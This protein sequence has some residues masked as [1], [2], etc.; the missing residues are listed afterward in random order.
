MKSNLLTVCLGCIGFATCAADAFAETAYPLYVIETESGTL[1]APVS[2]ESLS[3]KKYAT[4]ES[5]EEET[6]FATISASS[7]GAGTFVKRGSGY[8]MGSVAFTNFTGEVRVEKGAWVVDRPGMCGSNLSSASA[9]TFAV[10]NGAAFVCAATSASFPS[11]GTWG[12]CLIRYTKFFFEGTGPDGLGAL[13]NKS[14]VSMN[15]AC[16]N[17]TMTLTGDATFGEIA[18]VNT[19]FDLGSYAVI[20]LQG[21]ELVI[22]NHKSTTAC[23][24]VF[25]P[26]CTMK[27]P[28]S[29]R[30][31]GTGILFQSAP[32]F[33]GDSS[34]RFTF[35]K[36]AALQTWNAAMTSARIPWTLC[37]T[38]NSSLSVSR[39]ASEKEFDEASNYFDAPVVIDQNRLYGY[40]STM[41][42]GLAFNGFVSG[43]G[44][45]YFGGEL[46]LA[47][48]CP[49]NSFD[50]PAVVNGNAL[51]TYSS[52]LRLGADGALPENGSGAKLTNAF[53]RLT[54]A[55]PY[56]LPQLDFHTQLARPT[57]YWAEGGTHGTVAGLRKTGAQTLEWR[58]PLSV[59][60]QT[61]IVEGTL[62]LMPAATP[63]IL[64]SGTPGLY[65]WIIPNANQVQDPTMAYSIWNDPGWAVVSNNV[66][67]AMEGLRQST[68][69]DAWTTHEW[70]GYVWNR[71]PTNETW[72]F[73][74]G[75]CGYSRLMIDRK[76]EYGSDNNGAIVR[77]NLTITPGPHEILF[78]VNA[79]S[80]GGHGS[81]KN[82]PT[83]STNMGLAIDRYGRSTTNA[84]DYVFPENGHL[85]TVIGGDGYW[86]TRDARTREEFTEDELALLVRMANFTAIKAHAGTV[87]DIS[88]P[89]APTATPLVV[90]DFV[91]A[92]TVTNG[93][94]WIA[95]SWTL[96]G[97]EMKMQ[98]LVLTDGALTFGPGV[99]LDVEDSGLC[100]GSRWIE[101][102]RA[103]EGIS[104]CPRLSDMLEEGNWELK[105]E[106]HSLFIRHNKGTVVIVK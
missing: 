39:S 53:L 30:A 14:T 90:Q 72:T 3:V 94:I 99:T 73:A 98:P 71:S 2:V 26:D 29:I 74:R 59:T 21:H 84:V 18:A 19:R 75:I 88:M 17:T 12:S 9:P 51:Y 28:G 23:N 66:V 77:D 13:V 38:G 89:D 81:G 69:W 83:W 97:G 20:D 52:V 41:G 42:N 70:H 86:F 16:W 11:S 36:G 82:V 48:N 85:D 92:N 37:F 105:V 50:G 49:S 55:V 43:R 76:H 64:Y 65:E 4:A 45:F 15:C 101:I 7:L 5:E 58:V 32:A 24:G 78:R 47:L 46:S 8:V 63:D 102:A 1:D 87:L 44:G 100:K 40:S 57:N 6:D 33:K 31:E 35:D 79:R 54:K 91:G 10:S 106:G 104:G 103:K 68:A 27:N 96:L 95:K 67:G 80:Y 34:V 93:S 56:H 22:K 60:G 61:E 25:T 62:R